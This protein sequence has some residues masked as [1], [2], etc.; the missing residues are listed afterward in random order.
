MRTHVMLSEAKHLK[1]DEQYIL[2]SFAVCAAQD[3]GVQR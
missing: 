2:R 1:I 3:D